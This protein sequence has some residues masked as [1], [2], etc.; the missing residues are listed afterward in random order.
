M[1][2]GREAPLKEKYK[3]SIFRNMNIYLQYVYCILI[4][5][6]YIKTLLHPAGEH[7]SH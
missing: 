4:S 6:F 7:F 3:T 2:G 1:G 5:K